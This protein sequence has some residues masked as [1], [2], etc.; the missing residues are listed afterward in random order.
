[1]GVW[2]M[3]MLKISDVF[4]SL[5]LQIIVSIAFCAFLFIFSSEGVSIGN[6]PMFE[7]IFLSYGL[8]IYLGSVD[9]IFYRFV[10]PTSRFLWYNKCRGFERFFSKPVH[11][12]C[13]MEAADAVKDRKPTSPQFLPLKSHQQ[14]KQMVYI[15][16]LD[17]MAGI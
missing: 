9:F 2:A 11:L 13:L 16:I 1:M 6:L 4:L 12:L 10:K 8:I 15:R 3:K 5:T 14:K 17:S 7:L